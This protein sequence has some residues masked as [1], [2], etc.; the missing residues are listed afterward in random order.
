MLEFGCLQGLSWFYSLQSTPGADPRVSWV[1]WGPHGCG[2]SYYQRLVSTFPHG[3]KCSEQGSGVG[4]PG[5]ASAPQA[6]TR[7]SD[8]VTEHGTGL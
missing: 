1:G 4:W 2:A 5:V 7:G 6:V 3:V 8:Q